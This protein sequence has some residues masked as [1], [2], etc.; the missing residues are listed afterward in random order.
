MR[1]QGLIYHEIE[2][3]AP[4]QLVCNACGE[5]GVTLAT[6][7]RLSGMEGQDVSHILYEYR[8]RLPHDYHTPE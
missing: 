6:E 5:T 7:I 4:P 3:A 2:G 1:F 8:F